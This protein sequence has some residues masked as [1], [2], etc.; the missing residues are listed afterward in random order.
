[1]SARPSKPRPAADGSTLEVETAALLRLVPGARVSE[2]VLVKGKKVDLLLDLVGH[3]VADQRIAIECK[4]W[5]RPLTRRQAAQIASEYLPMVADHAVDQFWLVTRKGVGPNAQ[6]VFNGR[7]SLHLTVKDLMRKLF[8]PLPLVHN[9]IAQ[10]EAD[11]LIDDYI[12]LRA[13]VPNLHLA[14]RNYELLYNEFIELALGERL[15]FREALAFW[16]KYAESDLFSPQELYNEHLFDEVIRERATPHVKDLESYVMAWLAAPKVTS[17][18]ALLGSYGTG[19]SS[20]AR[21]LAHEVAVA[22]RDGVGERV[23]LLIELKEFGAH[24]DIGGLVTHELVNRH[25][26]PNASYELFRALNRSGFFLI[27]LD[28]FDEMKQGMT[29]DSL[30]YNFH[31]I[32][33]LR[34]GNAKVLLCGRPTLFE[35]Q[36]EQ[37]RLLKGS[38]SQG[39]ATSAQFIHLSVQPFEIEE[40]CQYLIRRASRGAPGERQRMTEFVRHLRVEAQVNR[41]LASIIARPVHLPMLAVVVPRTRLMPHELRRSALYREF[42]LDIIQREMLKRRHE[43]QATYPSDARFRFARQL[44]VEMA[45]RGES[46]SI[47]YSEIP[48]ELLASFVRPGVPMQAV[49]RDLVVACFLERKPPDILYVP[50]KSFLEFLVADALLEAMQASEVR[51]DDIGALASPEVL[52]FLMEMTTDEEWMRVFDRASYN[53]ALI[54]RFTQSFLGWEKY[55]SERL[56]ASWAEIFFTFPRRTREAL[57]SHYESVAKQLS[58]PAVAVLRTALRDEEYLVSV[59]AYRALAKFG[60]A[61]TV[62]EMI[63]VAGP[64]SL[65][66]WI[67]CKWV[68]WEEDDILAVMLASAR[69]SLLRVLERRRGQLE[70][71]VAH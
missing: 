42:I 16:T 43:F 33:A 32:G 64:S 44:C 18:L 68:S 4:D 17:G 50:H 11:G 29:T 70:A 28:G 9:M 26:V 1:M 36:L 60:K 2:Q 39:H 25:G 40:A 61:P 30:L 55:S 62:H 19:K 20:F 71:S 8:N 53:T 7:T 51:T 58:T 49:R 31:Q 46:R 23:P 66:E 52:S 41:D 59:H 69:L 13:A 56:E 14:H 47:R 5:R 10:F 34:E 37:N 67:A 35:S 54:G 27:I 24:Q 38:S 57:A 6:S 45:K 3:I 15:S 65:E 63:Q 22:H 21:R 12:P 48:D